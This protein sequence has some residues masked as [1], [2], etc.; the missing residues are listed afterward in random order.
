V[1]IVASS[2]VSVTRGEAAE[3][4]RRQYRSAMPETW[5][6]DVRREGTP[7]SRML[8]YEHTG[9]RLPTVSGAPRGR[10]PRGLDP[11]RV[12][13]QASPAD[14]LGLPMRSGLVPD[15][16]AV[17]SRRGSVFGQRLD[18]SFGV[19]GDKVLT[20]A[21]L[22]RRSKEFGSP[23]S[24]YL[25]V[26]Q[27]VYG[28]KAQLYA[29][30]YDWVQYRYTPQQYE[31]VLRG[32]ILVQR[33]E[34]GATTDYYSAAAVKALGGE[35]AIE[36][37]G[38]TTGQA[39][40]YV[41][42]V[43]ATVRG[44]QGV[45]TPEAFGETLTRVY[46]DPAA[47]KLVVSEHKERHGVL[48]AIGL[49]GLEKTA[50]AL[51]PAAGIIFGREVAAV[52][53]GTRGIEGY[54]R[55][56]T[57]AVG[58]RTA[59]HLEQYGDMGV[60]LTVAI[61]TAAAPFTGGATAAPAVTLAA[62]DRTL[63]AAEANASGTNAKWDRVAWDTAVDVGLYV[64]GAKLATEAQAAAD[65]AKATDAAT[66][67]AQTARTWQA[68]N[69]VWSLGGSA[70]L[71]A[72]LKGANR[73]DAAWAAGTAFAGGMLNM[74]EAPAEIQATWAATTSLA[75]SAFVDKSAFE[76]ALFSASMAGATAYGGARMGQGLQYLAD[77]KT[78]TPS[79]RYAAWTSGMGAQ[80]GRLKNVAQVTGE[81]AKIGAQNLRGVKPEGYEA[82][83]GHGGL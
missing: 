67:T 74:D 38:T 57:D 61:L 46:G 63:Q 23:A 18:E 54:D 25:A 79:D 42:P 43:D 68:A 11:H 70:Y 73:T 58:K 39:H 6:R 8:A 51:S 44:G 66:K 80:A 1:K 9:V 31:Q 15:Q 48:G 35:V 16:N 32:N 41:L 21:E 2:I 53:G 36:Q 13:V 59:G 83:M 37:L 78:V 50:G 3:F 34:Q 27:K 40:T 29:E 17:S 26:R 71:G 45:K 47:V 76:D 19:E 7:A 4:Y 55:T 64:V 24:E 56:M 82:A 5:F 49:E 33:S 28:D 65:A 72:M 12:A 75:K 69:T 77:R 10:D 81:W 20:G 62:V 52:L 22:D 60:K 30:H 14:Y